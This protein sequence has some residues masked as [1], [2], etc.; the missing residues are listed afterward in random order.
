MCLLCCLPAVPC[1]FQ[2][3]YA[4]CWL[5]RYGGILVFGHNSGML[6]GKGLALGQKTLEHIKNWLV[7]RAVNVHCCQDIFWDTC[8][9]KLF[10]R[11]CWFA[12][13]L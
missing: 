1:G 13:L 9:V 7:H 11:W 5:H 12:W 10:N 2:H 3:G 8:D 4:V 6:I